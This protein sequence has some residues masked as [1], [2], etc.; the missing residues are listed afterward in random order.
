MI[1][2]PVHPVRIRIHDEGHHIGVEDEEAVFHGELVG[3]QAV[4]FVC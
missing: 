2:Q 3:G 1:L 4:G